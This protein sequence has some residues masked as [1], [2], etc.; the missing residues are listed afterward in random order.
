MPF[1]IFI[2]ALALTPFA[3]SIRTL[4]QKI[5]KELNMAPGFPLAA[6]VQTL[7]TVI[8]P[9]VAE[10]ATS[11]FAALEKPG[12]LVIPAIGL[13]VAIGSVGLTPTGNMGVLNNPA[14]VS[15]Y[16]NGPAPGDEGSAVIAAHVFQSFAKLKDVKPG[17]SIYVKRTDGSVLHFIVS[18]IDVYPYNATGS[19]A[20]IFSR[21]DEP[22][23]NLITCY[24]VLTPD[25]TTYNKRLVVFAELAKEPILHSPLSIR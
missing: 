3:S 2:L 10:A 21:S 1:I 25:R 12:Q 19:L 22:R 16:K 23:L 6:G 11:Q 15:W 18:E 4:S 14:K 7:G 24:G 17:N 20:K 13:N 5:E 9:L 8:Q